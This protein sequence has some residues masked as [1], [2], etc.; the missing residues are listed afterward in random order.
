MVTLY[1]SFQTFYT[2]RR[3]SFSR[4]AVASFAL[5]SSRFSTARYRRI[6]LPLGL[7]LPLSMYAMCD[8][9]TL[10]MGPGNAPGPR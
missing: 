9:R 7:R 3:N 6:G 5:R 10:S 1:A 4:A 2:F 8:A